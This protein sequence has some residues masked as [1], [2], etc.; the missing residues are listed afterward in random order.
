MLSLE[1]YTLEHQTV[2][3]YLVVYPQ[4]R[5][6]VYPIKDILAAPENGCNHHIIKM[7]ASI[8]GFFSIDTAYSTRYSFASP[9]ALGLRNFFLD[10]HYQG[11]GLGAMSLAEL[12]SYLAAQYTA[13]QWIYLTVNC[14][15]TC[16][17]KLYQRAGFKDSGELYYGGSSGPQYIMCRSF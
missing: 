7:G 10:C 11:K 6:Y 13:W 5:D 16:A 1:K 8:I 17:Y 12:P 14:K 3:S 15:N 2:V 9:A 4:Q